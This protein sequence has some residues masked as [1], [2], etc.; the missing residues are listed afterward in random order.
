[1]SDYQS[2]QRRI[3]H[4]IFVS[5]LKYISSWIILHCFGVLLYIEIMRKHGYLYKFIVI[6]A[7]DIVLIDTIV[8]G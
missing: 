6:H 3:L 7:I 5:A 8:S 2:I 4:K 1:M